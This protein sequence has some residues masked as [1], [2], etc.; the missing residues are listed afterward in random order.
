[1]LFILVHVTSFER[2]R[3]KK[4]KMKKGKH[5]GNLV[6]FWFGTFMMLFSST[7][8]LFVMKLTEDE[9]QV[10]TMAYTSAVFQIL[11]VLAYIM[12]PHYPYI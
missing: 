10:A 8:V 11:M 2:A 4:K 5:F 7:G 3:L 1:M 6:T 12:H 9:R